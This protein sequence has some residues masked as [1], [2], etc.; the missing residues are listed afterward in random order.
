[1]AR[2]L[3]F[4]AWNKIS[5]EM[6]DWNDCC[7][8]NKLTLSNLLNGIILHI[9]PMQYTGFKDKNGKEIYEGD[10]IRQYTGGYGSW[11]G[12]V[13]FHPLGAK[14]VIETNDDLPSWIHISKD[15]EI[16][17]NIYE[18]PNLLSNE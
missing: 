3:K 9:I 16:I 10:I 8:N 15:A 2:E 13:I 12:T 1:M 14:F 4:R 18:N 7:N 5:S 11:F 6:L 17:G